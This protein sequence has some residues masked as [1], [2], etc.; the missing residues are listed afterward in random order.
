MQVRNEERVL[1]RKNGVGCRD[2]GQR[3]LKPVSTGFMA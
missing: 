1:V 2:T 3:G